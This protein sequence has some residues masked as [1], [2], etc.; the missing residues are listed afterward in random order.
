MPL[1]CN[2]GAIVTTPTFLR[3]GI[4]AWLLLSLAGIVLL[5]RYEYQSQRDHF[6]QGASI[7][8]RMLSQKAVQHEAVLETLGALSHPPTPERLLPSLRPALAE[9]LGLGWPSPQGWQGSQPAPAGLEHAVERARTSGHAVVLPLDASHYWL[10]APSSWSMLIDAKRLLAPADIADDVGTLTLNVSSNALALREQPA[11]SGPLLSV[12]KI[13]GSVSQPFP[14]LASRRV[15]PADWPWLAW[16]GWMLVSALL[17]GAERYWQNSRRQAR[18]QTEQARLAALSR[19]NTLGEMAA[20]I[21]HELNQPLTAI[22]AQTRAAQRLM[23]DPDEASTVRQA[24]EASAQQARRA[25]DIIERLRALV[26]S[27]AAAVRKPLVPDSLAGNL[28]FLCEPELARHQISLEWTN[29][30]PATRALGDPIAVEQILHNLVQNAI[31]VLQTRSAPRRI[32]LRGD[33]RDGHYQFSVS[34][35]GPGIAAADFPHIFEPFYTTRADGMGL[36][37]ALCETLAGSMDARLTAANLPDGGA[38]FTLSL[39]LEP[40]A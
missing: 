5:G 26:G 10:V 23:D 20:G 38:C 30:A 16:V 39:P 40:A 7:A 25:A 18:R 3:R 14:M 33:V 17:V 28:G 29:T 31:A 19:L 12:A 21:A 11:S 37:L 9:L 1:P 22:L 15:A 34:D 36:G 8:H 2:N 24:L 35:N 6:L 4:V 32:R 13:L 27:G